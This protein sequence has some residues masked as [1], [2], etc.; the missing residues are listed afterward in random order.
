M[1]DTGWNMLKTIVD[2]CWR[3]R[4]QSAPYTERA[5]GRRGNERLPALGTTVSDE[6][7][8]ERRNE[9]G[10]VV[11]SGR[12]GCNTGRLRSLVRHL[13]LGARFCRYKAFGRSLMT[14]NQPSRP[15]AQREMFIIGV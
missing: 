14:C 10:L 3:E 4:T 9:R 11:V 1:W 13:V 7:N 2:K 15:D 8:N 6:G 12:G 5:V